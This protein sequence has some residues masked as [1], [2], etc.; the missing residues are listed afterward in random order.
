[1]D[2]RYLIAAALAA[3][4]AVAIPAGAADKSSKS[5]A[6]SGATSE[7]QQEFNKL[8][9]NHDGSISRAEAKGS[10][11]EKDF[12]KFDKN[13]DG[14]LSKQ[15]FSAAEKSEEAASGGSHSDKK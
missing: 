10:E 1:M 7:E 3:S 14:K 2:S 6:S 15:E 9:K 5:P 11:H 12:S 4:F 13:K 8:D